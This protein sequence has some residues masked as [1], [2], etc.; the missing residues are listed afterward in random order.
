MWGSGILMD[1]LAPSKILIDP[2][3]TISEVNMLMKVGNST[4]MLIGQYKNYSNNNRPDVRLH[5]S[6]RVKVLSYFSSVAY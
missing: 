2:D 1:T 3:S 5:Y 4:E 6:C